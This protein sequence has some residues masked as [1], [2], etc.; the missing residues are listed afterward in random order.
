MLDEETDFDF[1]LNDAREFYKDSKKLIDLSKCLSVANRLFYKTETKKVDR[2]FLFIVIDGLTEELD[3]QVESLSKLRKDLFG[4]EKK[5]IKHLLGHM[6]FQRSRLKFNTPAYKVFEIEIIHIKN[7]LKQI[8]KKSETSGIKGF[9]QNLCTIKTEKDYIRRYELFTVIFTEELEELKRIISYHSGTLDFHYDRTPKDRINSNIDSYPLSII[10]SPKN[11]ELINKDIE[12][13]QER[14]KVRK[15]D[16][17]TL[18]YTTKEIEKH[19][20]KY[21]KIKKYWSG[22]RFLVQSSP[23]S[24]YS[25]YRTNYATIATVEYKRNKWYYKNVYRHTEMERRFCW[26]NPLEFQDL[27]DVFNEVY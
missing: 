4:P 6:M 5:K 12:T 13:V 2:F 17:E 10:I 15:L 23:G 11:S 16:Y 25:R 22:A 21:M 7:Y 9:M 1:D 19:L 20:K 14:C 26:L 3:K 24:S 8:V 27:F 18:V